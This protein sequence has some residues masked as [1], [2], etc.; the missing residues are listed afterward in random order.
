MTGFV[1]LASYSKNLEMWILECDGKIF[2]G[3]FV[4]RL[5]LLSAC[6]AF[7]TDC[8]PLG[9]RIW[10]RPDKKYLFGRTKQEGGRYA[11]KHEDCLQPAVHTDLL[12]RFII[13]HKSVSRKHLTL[14]VSSVKPGEGVFCSQ[15]V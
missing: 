3:T 6:V 4:S 12:G 10:L 1:Q 8:E 2:Q 15:P 13:D 9:K 14:S 11:G 7:S 5:N